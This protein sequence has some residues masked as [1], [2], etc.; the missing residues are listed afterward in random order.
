MS[1][2][3]NIGAAALSTPPLWVPKHEDSEKHGSA[4]G[5]VFGKEAKAR[6]RRGSLTRCF[7]IILQTEKH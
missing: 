2:S 4:C 3:H 7:E 6:D 1:K 5:E